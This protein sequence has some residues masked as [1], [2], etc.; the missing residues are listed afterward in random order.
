VWREPFEGFIGFGV[1]NSSSPSALNPNALLENTGME[2]I[3]QPAP[4]GLTNYS[5][6]LN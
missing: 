2:A 4:H 1:W 5:Q 3:S 6:N